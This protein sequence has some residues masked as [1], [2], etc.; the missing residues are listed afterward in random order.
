VPQPTP[1]SANSTVATKPVETQAARPLDKTAKAGQGVSV[2]LESVRKIV[3]KAK[4]P[5]EVAGP[6]LAVSVKVDNDSAKSLDL[7]NVVV[8]L[9]DASDAPGSVMSTAPARRLPARV[10]AGGSASGVYVF[11]VPSKQ[12]KTV[13]VTVSITPGK[14]VLKFEGKPFTR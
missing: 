9:T 13:T 14:S 6:A 11:T 8:N 7:S 10:K 2:R 3:A 12:Q 5:G 1:G 4:L